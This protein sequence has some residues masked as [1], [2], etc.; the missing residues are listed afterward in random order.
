MWLFI[1]KKFFYPVVHRRSIKLCCFLSI[2]TAN[3]TIKRLFCT[4]R[5][6]LVRSHSSGG[7]R[8]S[9]LDMFYSKVC[10]FDFS[11]EKY[12]LKKNHRTN[13]D[14]KNITFLLGIFENL[15]NTKFQQKKCDTKIR[16]TNFRWKKS[17]T[18]FFFKNQKKHTF[19]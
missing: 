10:I 7:V 9:P 2:W 11:R 3:R 13:F 15:R 12:G 19:R 5:L 8:S 4:R 1:S 18:Y 16:S 14:H 6:C 17:K